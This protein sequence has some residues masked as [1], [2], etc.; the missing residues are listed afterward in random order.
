MT[1]TPNPVGR[2]PGFDQKHVGPPGLSPRGPHPRLETRKHLSEV[3]HLLPYLPDR[4]LLKLA[5][6]LTR[7]VV[8]VPDLLQR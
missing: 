5:N 4:L 3:A 7:K 2:A 8:F 6:P 1:D